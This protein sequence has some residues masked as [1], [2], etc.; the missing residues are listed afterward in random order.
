ME[1]TLQSAEGVPE[2]SVLSIK[3]GDTKRQG[4][5]S[6]VGQPF[7]FASSPA[8]P[9][10]MKVEILNLAAPAQTINLDPSKKS[11]VVDFGG[12]MKVTLAQRQAPELQR[13]AADVK[14]AASR[15]LSPDKLQT[16]Q[17]AAI[18]LEQHDLVRTFQDIL[19]GLLV[20]KPDDPMAYL[21]EHVARAKALDG[22]K[23]AAPAQTLTRT[24]DKA[25]AASKA[26][27]NI[28]GLWKI[29]GDGAEFMYS[30]TL[31]EDGQVAGQARPSNVASWTTALQGCLQGETLTWAEFSL[32]NGNQKG[33]FSASL[34]ADGE[35]LAG[36]GN[37]T[38]GGSLGFKGKKE[39]SSQ[40]KK[41]AQRG[42][43][44]SR[45]KVDA[46]MEILQ[47]TSKN[48]PLILP[49]LPQ[50]L[51][52][53]LTGP[54]LR[55][56]CEK[57]FKMLS[58]DRGKLGAAELLP[59]ILHL[60]ALGPNKAASVG[61]DQVNS[62]IKMFDANADG[63]ICFDEFTSLVQFVM[64]SAHLDT[65]E[66]K[67]L[68]ECV[69]IEETRF[70]DLLEIMETDRERINDIVPFLPDW[71]VIHLTCDE[72]LNNCNSRFDELDADRSGVLEPA[73]LLPVI[74]AL[75]R[76]DPSTMDQTKLMRFV[77]MFD[78]H[79]NGV[80]MRDEFV[81]FTQ[82]MAVMDFLESTV[83]G[84]Q[85]AQASYDYADRRQLKQSID[86]LRKDWTSLPQVYPG[87]PAALLSD[88]SSNQFANLCTE[89]FN[90]LDTD[91]KGLPASMLL[92]LL[93]KLCLEHA[94]EMNDSRCQ[95][96]FNCFDIEKKG[97]I[98]SGQ[99]VE[100]ARFCVVLGYFTSCFEWHDRS[101]KNSKKR[102]EE[103][104]VFLKGH[105]EKL[106]D[107]LPFLPAEFHEELLSYDFE[108][109]CMEDFR[110]LDKA[111]TGVLEPKELIP[112]I[113]HLSKGHHL[114]LEFDHVMEFVNLFDTKKNGV[115]TPSEFVNLSRFMMIIAYLESEEGQFVA[116]AVDVQQGVRQVDDLIEMM[117]KNRGAIHKIVPMLPAEV[118]DEITSDGFITECQNRFLLLDKDGN[119]TLEPAELYPVIVE[120]S[121]AHPYAIDL[122]HCKA[123]TSI[124][125]IHGNGVIMK[126]EFVDFVRFLFIMSYM[127]TPEGR[128]KMNDGIAIMD[129]ACQIDDLLE[130]LKK[131]RRDMRKV[132]PY[133]PDALRNELLG[134]EF[135]NQCLATFKSLDKDG[136]GSLDP[137]ELYPIILDMT[138]A[139]KYALDMDQCKKFTDIFDDE[140]TGVISQKEFV[141]FA[142]FL[143]VMSYLGTEDG[144][145]TLAVA[146]S[147]AAEAKQQARASKQIKDTQGAATGSS[148]VKH[149][150]VDLD[151]YKKKSDK[152][153]KEN[154]ALRDKQF[155]ME[156][157]I[158]RLENRVE[159]QEQRL[160]HAEL[161]LGKPIR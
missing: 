65:P 38:G 68:L 158:R 122:E 16:A 82:F 116:E 107:I 142:R 149:M 99:V 10:P 94:V 138:N 19:H 90:A 40:Q 59:I 76:A 46:L 93:G 39:K 106:D 97:V 145:K 33:E 121:Q 52:E 27:A 20:V 51:S 31:Y 58:G 103:L 22:N 75:T 48:L 30:F 28:T 109:H 57:Q 17:S 7:R 139:H 37:F 126:D 132:I 128:Q 161:D 66:G 89:H 113:L 117:R 81:D 49:M 156:D 3:I 50:E 4:A 15:G 45:S 144:K 134:N 78:A 11:L 73:E 114:A 102:I 36:T 54:S 123:F 130:V 119:G 8:E 72:F 64:I 133:L 23:D 135:T 152:L 14:D 136:N 80:I 115:I 34:N 85:V 101:V 29:T 124:F 2:G 108:R 47:R 105:A 157:T 56:E 67:Q 24:N 98:S 88:I 140:R 131:D 100:F 112:V 69:E 137:E 110:D 62:F 61:E 35:T 151:F 79:N 150:A 96:F 148:D 154:D 146:T 5:V 91:K 63:A 13:P 44:T 6:N 84:Q 21:Q 32:D 53:V 120:L 12:Q 60:S 159:D 74:V 42:S 155:R 41:A 95:E 153:T 129:S 43:I 1:F 26:A 125:D 104:I 83:E 55:E 87:L 147:D 160:R 127:E 25:P 141:N 77:K 86:M 70:T 92:S 118:Y 9:L 111:G 71:L 18:Y 143:M